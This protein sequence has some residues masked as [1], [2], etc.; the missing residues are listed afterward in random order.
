MELTRQG[1]TNARPN[2]I[3]INCVLDALAKSGQASRAEQ[4]LTR[5]EQD[6]SNDAV[7]DGIRLNAI[8]Y[9]CVI[10][11]YAKS[12]EK[13][14]AQRAEAVFKR[15]DQAY[16]GGNEDAKPTSQSFNAGTS[17]ALMASCS[18]TPYCCIRISHNVPCS[19]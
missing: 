18:M 13:G 2:I 12:P 10:D 17:T 15:M 8:S 6:E 16:R 5:I 9:T 14:A 1:R 11:A 19:H 3:T 4:L 7:L